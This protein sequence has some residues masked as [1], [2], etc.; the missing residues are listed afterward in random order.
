MCNEIILKLTEP[1]L[2][3]YVFF[4]VINQTLSGTMLRDLL[5]KHLTLG[6]EYFSFLP[7]I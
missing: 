6:Y 3:H 4:F 1:R 2:L 7:K 5:Q